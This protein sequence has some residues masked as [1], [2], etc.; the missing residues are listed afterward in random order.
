MNAFSIYRLVCLLL[1]ALLLAACQPISPAG[2]TIPPAGGEGISGDPALLA[3]LALQVFAVYDPVEG[4]FLPPRILLGHLPAHLPFDF[5]LPAGMAVVGSI[6]TEAG[7]TGQIHLTSEQPPREAIAG[8]RSSLVAAGLEEL[9]SMPDPVGFQSDSRLLDSL[10]LCTADRDTV[11]WANAYPGADATLVRLQI[12]QSPPGGPCAVFDGPRGGQEQ[13]EPLVAL[14]APADV[15]S[16]GQG[17][18]SGPDSLWTSADLE[19]ALSA[20]ELL[21][22][23]DEQLAAAGWTMLDEG[24]D[25][26]AAWSTWRV[27]DGEGRAWAGALTLFALAT[28]PQRIAATLRVDRVYDKHPPHAN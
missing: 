9:R 11:L 14:V 4:T 20:A 7:E 28:E 23:Y 18:S 6:T 1:A 19:T 13:M 10:M 25:E 12:E 24:V 22:T 16:A 26:R 27:T 21:A 5:A 15:R 3:P 2:S 17:S 8:L